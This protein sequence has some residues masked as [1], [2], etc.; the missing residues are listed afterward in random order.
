MRVPPSVL[1]SK[2]MCCLRMSFH[3]SDRS[4]TMLSHGLMILGIRQV[5]QSH[6]SFLQHQ[7]VTEEKSRHG[8]QIPAGQSLINATSDLTSVPTSL[9]NNPNILRLSKHC[10]E[11]RCVV[12][13]NST[14]GFTLF[15]LEK[16]VLVALRKAR[17]C[18]DSKAMSCLRLIDPHVCT[19]YS[20]L[21]TTQAKTN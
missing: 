15:S 18:T 17:M 21:E 8:N 7:K 6:V 20:N 14:F 3:T 10:Q 19:L 12:D 5:S 16:V 1:L 11:G 2:V 4:L 13:N 9:A